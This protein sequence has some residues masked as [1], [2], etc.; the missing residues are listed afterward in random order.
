MAVIIQEGVDGIV[1]IENDH[2]G[3]RVDQM[4]IGS[5]SVFEGPIS[6]RGYVVELGYNELIQ[7]DSQSSAEAFIYKL[8]KSEF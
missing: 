2:T 4:L 3:R 6:L 7:F 8:A 1:S 5:L